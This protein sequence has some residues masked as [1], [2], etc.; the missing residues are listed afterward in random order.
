MNQKP[1]S[2][3]RGFISLMKISRAERLVAGESSSLWLMKP[4]DVASAGR[5]R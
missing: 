5:E 1:F 2:F 4:G 3:D